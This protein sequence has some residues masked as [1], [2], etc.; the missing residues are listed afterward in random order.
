MSLQKIKESLYYTFSKENLCTDLVV[1]S[2]NSEYT[3][4][5]RGE[6]FENII[7]FHI[8]SKENKLSLKFK[9]IFKQRQVWIVVHGFRD[10]FEQDGMFNSICKSI[11]KKYPDDLVI[12]VCWKD[13]AIGA[14]VIKSLDVHRAATWTGPI[15]KGVFKKLQLWGVDNGSNL[16][17]IG[18][19]LGSILV[20]EIAREC[21]EKTQTKVEELIAIEVPSETLAP[22]Y[23]NGESDRYITQL[24]PRTTRID[25]LQLVSV[26]SLSVV[27]FGSI[28]TNIDFARTANQIELVTF[29]HPLSFIKGHHWVV[30]Y[31]ANN[32]NKF[33]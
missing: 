7:N 28:A 8:F 4:L 1:G 19:S 32:I 21:L 26:K 29:K 23:R 15:S 17:L 18:H 10:S 14:S 2:E 30:E 25:S 16:H 20:T 11:V 27:A 31:F 5:S 3:S 13:L 24:N 6:Y 22:L 33:I 12:G 9:N